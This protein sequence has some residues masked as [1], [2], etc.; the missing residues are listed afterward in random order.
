MKN[1]LTMMHPLLFPQKLKNSLGSFALLALLFC[2][3]PA[4]AQHLVGLRGAVNLSGIDFQNNDDQKRITTFKNFSLLY[5]YYHP[6]WK[7]FPYF[8]FQTGIAYSETGFASHDFLREHHQELYDTTRYKVLTIPLISQFHVDFW[9]M[10]ILVNIGAFGG[11]R[12]SAKE[13]FYTPAGEHIKRDYLFDCYD[14]R[15]DYGI[16]GGGGL[17][18]RIKPFEIHFEC[19][20]HYSLAMLYSPRKYSNAYYIYVYPNQLSFSLALHFQLS[21]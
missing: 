16:I 19:N 13:S 2:C 5:T 10:R 21:K 15:A 12:L 7:L 8:G 9:K 14:I 18:F 3:A 20:Y 1:C 17:A 4:H 11:Y 6:M